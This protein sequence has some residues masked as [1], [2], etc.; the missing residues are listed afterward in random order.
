MQLQ[1]SNLVDL[2]LGKP[3][4]PECENLG[5]L[6]TLLHVLLRK[7]NLS[8]TRI[9]LTDD[10]AELAAGLMKSMPDEPSMC[11]KEVRFGQTTEL[12]SE[13]QVVPFKYTLRGDGSLVRKRNSREIC[14]KRSLTQVRKRWPKC[15]VPNKISSTTV[16]L[17]HSMLNTRASSCQTMETTNTDVNE[18]V[19]GL[20]KK[21]DEAF[22]EIGD[23]MACLDQEI[24][25][26]K[27]QSSKQSVQNRG[28]FDDFIKLKTDFEKFLPIL[29]KL[30]SLDQPNLDFFF[31]KMTPSNCEVKVSMRELL[32]SGATST[33]T[34]EEEED[35]ISEEL[36]WIKDQILELKEANE[37][38][39]QCLKKLKFND[40]SR[41][42]NKVES[43]VSEQNDAK[44]AQIELNGMVNSMSSQEIG[45]LQRE[46]RKMKNELCDLRCQMKSFDE[47][48]EDSKCKA[49]EMMDAIKCEF[50]K[51]LTLRPTT[52]SNT[53]LESSEELIG[54]ANLEKS[55]VGHRTQTGTSC[56]DASHSTIF[57]ASTNASRSTKASKSSKQSRS[58]RLSQCTK[59]SQLSEV[60]EEEE[61]T[62]EQFDD[63]GQTGDHCQQFSESFFASFPSPNIQM[64]QD[65]CLKCFE[66]SFEC[67]NEGQMPTMFNQY[68]EYPPSAYQECGFSSLQSERP[69]KCN[70]CCDCREKE[71]CYPECHS[72]MK[73][74]EDMS[75]LQKQI[76]SHKMC[77]QQLIHDMAMK[78]DRC[79][80]EK[81][82]RQLSET[83]DLVMKLRND[84]MTT[85]AGCA[86]P[87]MRNV[88]CI[89]CQTTTNMTIAAGPNI[90]KVRPLKYGR[91][92]TNSTQVGTNSTC[93]TLR[94]HCRNISN[95]NWRCF[96]RRGMRRAGG[97]H[98]KLS[99]AMA[100]NEMRFKR[101]KTPTRVVSSIMLYKNRFRKKCCQ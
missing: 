46:N 90:P 85:A 88:N 26:L 43:L 4:T 3:N 59:Q 29:E 95:S 25:E 72:G 93:A 44:C 89:S 32:R 78:L 24:S 87:L 68:A 21:I 96:S 76:E 65:P 16:K 49:A 18:A 27:S 38:H 53:T 98:T 19:E 71:F 75:Y 60:N 23:R 92:G 47:K 62:T 42:R 39:C 13:S 79:E 77:L 36:Q 52:L 58:T 31:S 69:M 67:A 17:D 6:H 12:T 34:E 10:M 11:F 84:Q 48:L 101:L 54:T 99:K 57:S 33:E 50:E 2:A 80:F 7:M 45:G 81:C 73:I 37:R 64:N 55:D 15:S 86:I 70:T 82:R 8:N 14:V 91:V 94:T 22:S 74:S 83:I 5:F 97:S 41:L 28:A 100:V 40:F 30:G 56:S 51:R 20:S 35:V 66:Q 61:N 1:L 9:E 63:E